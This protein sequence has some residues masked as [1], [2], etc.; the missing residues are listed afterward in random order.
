VVAE[1]ETPVADEPILNYRDLDAWNVAMDL[2]V[3][4]YKVAGLL[5]SSELFA[6]SA[7]IRRAAV[8][9]PSNIAEGHAYGT[10]ARCVYHLRVA[11]GSVGELDTDFE[12]AVRLQFV[13][14][15]Q[16]EDVRAQLARTRQLLYGLLRA[17]LIQV[18]KATGKL[19]LF[20]G[21]S[22]GFLLTVLR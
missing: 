2:S 21:P 12:L 13:T 20:L 16:L 8:S 15:A 10:P 6:L 1:T 19:A 18:A 11:I 22:I 7:Q 4:A 3:M 9:V 14:A 5:P 17:K